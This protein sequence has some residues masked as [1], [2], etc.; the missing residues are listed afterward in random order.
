MMMMT[1]FSF[2]CEMFGGDFTAPANKLNFSHLSQRK[3]DLQPP[4]S[5]KEKSREEKGG[6]GAS[7]AFLE[8]NMLAYLPAWHAY[9]LC[10]LVCCLSLSLLSFHSH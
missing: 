6:M 3:E 1:L 4:P 7:E 9:K 8:F 5:V 2:L 10:Q